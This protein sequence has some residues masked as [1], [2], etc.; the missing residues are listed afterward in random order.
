M[1]RRANRAFAALLAFVLGCL[2]MAPAAAFAEDRAVEVE[3]HTI[4]QGWKA[5]VSDIRIGG[6]DAPAAG[7][8]L[9]DTAQVTTAEG[10][11]WDIPVLWVRDD[12]A[13]MPDS[14]EVVEGR[15]FLPVFAFFVPD[16]YALQ[17][18]DCKI[19]LAEDLAALFGPDE[20]ISVYS[21]GTGITYILP[22]S[23]KG[24]FVRAADGP[25]VSGDAKGGEPSVAGYATDGAAEAAKPTLLDI[26]CAQTARDALTD[27]DL[28][29]LIDLIINRLEPQAVNL[30]LDRFPAFSAAADKG[31]IGT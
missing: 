15:T 19:T 20:I 12:L 27:E 14:A 2:I 26:H 22:A 13:I 9:D 23:L 3:N 4:A 25:S 16:G 7:T 1:E 11:G 17:D 24:L 8:Q 21:E 5:A 6:V 31:E 30:L 10:A 29:W 18:P 28:A